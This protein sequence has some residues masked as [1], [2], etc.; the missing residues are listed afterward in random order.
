MDEEVPGTAPADGAV[1]YLIR[2]SHFKEI[3]TH[4]LN[5]FIF[6]G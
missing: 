3:V 1:R 2:Y 4:R 6:S 5:E